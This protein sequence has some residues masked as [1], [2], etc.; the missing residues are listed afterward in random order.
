VF[1]GVERGSFWKGF[2]TFIKITLYSLSALPRMPLNA[3]QRRKTT[4]GRMAHSGPSWAKRTVGIHIEFSLLTREN[5]E[6]GSV[7]GTLRSCSRTR[8]RSAIRGEGKVMVSETPP[9]K[10]VLDGDSSLLCLRSTHRNSAHSCL[11]R[12]SPCCRA[13]RC[14]GALGRGVEMCGI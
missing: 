9:A 2:L 1:M 10:I 12:A 4:S 14:G 8:P 7:F 13:A 5:A 6:N 3:L 11:D